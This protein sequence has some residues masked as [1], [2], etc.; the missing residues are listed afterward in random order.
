MAQLVI[1]V[2]DDLAAALDELVA[3]GEVASR[4]AGVRLALE[5]LID[6]FHRDTVGARIVE[7]YQAVPQTD[8]EVAW[9]DAATASM[10]AEE[11]W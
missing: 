6:R 5:R 2:D 8:D 11:P 7:G 10:I 9:A 3:A 1:R 4:S